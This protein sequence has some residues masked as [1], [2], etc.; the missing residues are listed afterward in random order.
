M[1]QS[2]L[3]SF[4]HYK[5]GI[6][7]IDDAHWELLQIIYRIRDTDDTVDIIILVNEL[8]VAF[9]DHISEE[10]CYMSGIKFKYIEAHRHA[11][12]SMVRRFESIKK[13]I[14]E[15]AHDDKYDNMYY[16]SSLELMLKE[17][18]DHHDMQIK[19]AA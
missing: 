13:H 2:D 17:H 6:K 3:D 11:H 8:V 15:N 18:I 10:E 7:C 14:I 5:V 9:Y 1:R 16:C 19:E 12:M 4:V